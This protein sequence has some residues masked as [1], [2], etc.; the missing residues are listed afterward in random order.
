[1]DTFCHPPARSG[2]RG[3]LVDDVEQPKE[4][5]PLVPQVPYPCHL[6]PGL[7]LSLLFLLLDG[8][9]LDQLTVQAS[10][11]KHQ[12]RAKFTG[13][14]MPMAPGS[15]HKAFHRCPGKARFDSGPEVL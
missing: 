9:D 15:Q 5:L 2:L 11:N 12:G 14:S 13:F 3:D 4:P 8:L 10:V 1:M 7:L 6:G